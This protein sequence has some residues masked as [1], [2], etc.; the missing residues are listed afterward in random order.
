MADFDLSG[1]LL[2]FSNRMFGGGG[3]YDDLL[4]EEQRKR[5]AGDS[6]T[7]MAAA[8]LK[9][10]GP[11]TQRIGLGQALGSALEAGAGAAERGQM[12]A[13]QQILM[14]QKIDEAKREA[15]GNEAWQKILAGGQPSAPIQTPTM[16]GTAPSDNAPAGPGVV[17]SPVIDQMQAAPM[18]APMPSAMPSAMPAQAAQPSIFDSLTREQ[19]AL[20]STMPRK[21]GVPEV[22]KMSL[23]QQ[24][25]GKPE[26]VVMNGKTVMLQYNKFGQ[27]KIAEGAMPYEAQSPDIRAVEYLQGTALAGT[28]QPGVKAVGQYRE[29][30]APKINVKVP[31]D[32]T[33]GQ[34]GFTNEM[35]LGGAFK[36]EPI[37]KDFS[38]MKSAYGQVNSALAQGTPIGDVAGATKVMKLLD[39]GSVVRESELGLAMAASGRMDRLQNYFQNWASGRKLTPTQV[40][41]FKSLSSE[42]Y[43]AAGQAYNQKRGEYRDFGDAYKFKNLDTALGA[44]ASLP[45]ATKDE[46]KKRKSL[47]NIFGSQ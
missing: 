45:S 37:Y 28:G 18:P 36:Q 47:G 6:L 19:R 38:D 5:I 8:L 10:G 3:G 11:S 2:N 32:M 27:T 39:P 7:S 4:T 34:E 33:S 1:G 24:E 31:V 15:T 26:P 41:D 14:R 46:Q 9:A 35:K 42:L 22:L 16:V 21:E 30:I 29:Q 13:V 43:S 17:V 23:A 25:W 44:P 20:I 40:E 12:N